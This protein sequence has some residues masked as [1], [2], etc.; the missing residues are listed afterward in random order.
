MTTATRGLCPKQQLGHNFDIF[1]WFTGTTQ[2]AF[3]SSAWG[4]AAVEI[5]DFV[6]LRS[7][8]NTGL[9]PV[10]RFAGRPYDGCDNR[11]VQD[12]SEH[13]LAALTAMR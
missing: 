6:E 13:G 12:F 10:M 5:D 9:P 3:G 2:R 1:T 7:Y 8:G 11:H 4:G